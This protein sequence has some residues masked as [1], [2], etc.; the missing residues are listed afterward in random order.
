MSSPSLIGFEGAVEVAVGGADV[1]DSVIADGEIALPF[2]IVGIARRELL[3][4][5]E[6]VLIGFHRAVVVSTGGADIADRIVADGEIVLPSSVVWIAGR[7]L[8]GNLK[9]IRIGFHRAVV[10]SAGGADVADALIATE[11]SCCHSAL[12]G[13]RLDQV[14]NEGALIPA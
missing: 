14:I 1:A 10:V 4:N 2:C 9:P 13:S 5:V 12:F 3:S 8:L 7:E 11:R 6:P